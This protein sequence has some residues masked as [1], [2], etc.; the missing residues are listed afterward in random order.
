[1]GL[2]ADNSARKDEIAKLVETWREEARL[3]ER[4][5]EPRHMGDTFYAGNRAATATLNQ[6]ADR[7]E[8]ALTSYEEERTPSGGGWQRRVERVA[9]GLSEALRFISRLDLDI[10]VRLSIK[11]LRDVLGQHAKDA[12]P[13]TSRG[14]GAT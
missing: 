8:A 9:T 3:H 10:A 11:E 14:E 7:L 4:A 13:P 12:T 6:C 2:V 5:N 1:M